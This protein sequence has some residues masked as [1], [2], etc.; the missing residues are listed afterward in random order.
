MCLNKF[1]EIE[2]T[3]RHTVTDWKRL[4]NRKKWEIKN[5]IAPT[6][7]QNLYN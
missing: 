1:E 3:G 5:E 2:N 6:K 7:Y 4:I